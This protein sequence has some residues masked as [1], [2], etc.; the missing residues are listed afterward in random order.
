MNFFSNK[1]AEALTIILV[2]IIL[3]LF[4]GWLVSF[5]SREC[6][7]NAQCPSDY[8]CGSD[9]SCH[10]LPTIEKT[11]IKNNLVVPSIIMGIAIIVAA[12]I[13]RFGKKSFKTTKEETAQENTNNPLNMP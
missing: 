3:V 9:F 4:I 10:Q 8:Y 12:L 11:V 13:L 7:S 1:K 5:N 2:I 6:R